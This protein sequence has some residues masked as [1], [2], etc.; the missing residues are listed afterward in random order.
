MITSLLQKYN[1]Y[2]QVSRVAYSKAVVIFSGPTYIIR[3]KLLSMYHHCT[4]WHSGR[5]L[6]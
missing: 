3:L 2:Q 4:W 5:V 6:D 1:Q